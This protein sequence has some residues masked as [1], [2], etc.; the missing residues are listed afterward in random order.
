MFPAFLSNLKFQDT[1]FLQKS[2]FWGLLDQKY[3][4]W[5]IF[6]VL[7]VLKNIKNGRF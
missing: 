4:L 5:R 6:L 1:M 3:L 7:D 2:L